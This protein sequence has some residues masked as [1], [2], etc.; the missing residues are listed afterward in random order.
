MKYKYLLFALFLSA[1]T[2]CER[3]NQ[4]NPDNGD[5]NGD[6]GK[7]TSVVNV[8]SDLCWELTTDKAMYAP[9]ETVR[10]TATGTPTDNTFVR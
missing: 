8:T 2:S 4:Q 5:D 3:N 1:C 10:I 9:G 6:G 7:V